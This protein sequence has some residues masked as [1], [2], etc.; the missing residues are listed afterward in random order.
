MIDLEPTGCPGVDALIQTAQSLAREPEL[1]LSLEFPR[2]VETLQSFRRS[3]EKQFRDS[4][5]HYPKTPAI[6]QLREQLD[7]EF[8]R[9]RAGGRRLESFLEENRTDDLQTGCQRVHQAVQQLQSLSAQLRAQDEVWRQQYGAGLAAELKFLISQT[10][11]GALSYQQASLALEKSLEACRELEEGMGKVKPESD[12]VSE[13]LDVCTV[14]LAGF[15]RS[16]QRALQSLRMQHSWEIE[17]RL[18]DLLEA[19]DSLSVSHT[20]LMQALYPPVVCPHCG[21]LQPGDRP[22]CGACSARLPLPPVS[23]LPPPPTPEA[24]PRFHSFVEIEGKLEQWLRGESEPESCEKPIDQFRQR[25]QQGRRQIER[26]DALH[27]E[28]KKL[29]LQATEH[30]EKALFALKEAI[31][32]KDPI[33]CER[34][35]ELLREAEELMIFAQQRA[36][37]LQSTPNS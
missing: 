12:T 8:E 7:Q 13:A 25:L 20:Q 24:R 23:V 21:Q 19:V 15:N 29:L 18:Q 9:F 37:E 36:Q 3:L 4:L 2:H 26:D 17:E 27:E 16:L 22:Q 31:T 33:A 11:V 32:G 14:A 10:M 5:R 34:D 6:E 28:M 30:S 1:N 35:L